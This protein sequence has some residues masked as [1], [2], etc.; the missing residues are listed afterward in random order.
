MRNR[1]VTKS[2]VRI[3]ITAIIGASFL[4]AWPMNALSTPR[5]A[6]PQPPP[7][8]EWEWKNKNVVVRHSIVVRDGQV[9]TIRNS[10]I[11]MDSGYRLIGIH[12]LGELRIENSIIRSYKDV[13]YFFWIRGSATIDNSTIEGVRTFDPM[14][15]GILVNTLFFQVRHS[16]VRS[17]DEHAMTFFFPYLIDTHYVVESDVQ[18][19]MSLGTSVNAMNSSVGHLS[20]G[21]GVGEFYLWNCTYTG[22]SA[23]GGMGFVYSFKYLQVH[24]S[25]PEANLTITSVNGYE[26]DVGRTDD[27]GYYRSWWLSKNTIVSNIRST[28]FNYNPHTFEAWKTVEGEIIVVL[29]DG[30]TRIV[31]FSQD[32][33]GVTVQDLEGDSNVEVVMRMA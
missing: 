26:V 22:A 23:D 27:E 1:D 6:P 30:S 21:Y 25:L 11:E 3:I 28:E 29:P 8:S 5:I 2:A 7:F 4:T 9:L 18:G 19:M 14:A 15:E 20:V 31:S 16:T 12:V 33:Y 13:G 10:T 24:T 32:Y 17:Y